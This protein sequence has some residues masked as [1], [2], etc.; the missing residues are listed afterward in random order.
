[1]L[2]LSA[3]LGPT[4]AVA[5]RC[6]KLISSLGGA[7][8]AKSRWVSARAAAYK[9][10]GVPVAFHPLRV[11]SST[12][13]QVRG[14]MPRVTQA[15]VKERPGR[16]PRDRPRTKAATKETQTSRT[17]SPPP[18]RC[19]HV[20]PCLDCPR[21]QR[22]AA[23]I[24]GLDGWRRN[25]ILEAVGAALELAYASLVE[26]QQNERA[27]RGGCIGVGGGGAS[28]MGLVESAAV[29]V[30]IVHRA[31][32]V[33]HDVDAPS[34]DYEDDEEEREV[35]DGEEPLPDEEDDEAE[36]DEEER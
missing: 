9:R 21:I 19:W 1:V 33:A 20:N 23:L 26:E 25:K 7:R 4:E 15:T 10:W 30:D 29:G 35:D 34:K 6:V 22:V 3:G 13:Q 16:R 32:E 31:E 14:V 5:P 8:S 11:E 28:A 12:R 24:K 36:Q 17:K 18:K 27:T 2:L